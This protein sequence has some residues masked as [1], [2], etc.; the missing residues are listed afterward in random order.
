MVT[1]RSVVVLAAFKGWYI[2]QINVHNAFLNGD[3]F[4][5]VYMDIP[6]SFA[7]RWESNKV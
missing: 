1:I 3:L 5:E 7:R 2:N 6:P 4:E